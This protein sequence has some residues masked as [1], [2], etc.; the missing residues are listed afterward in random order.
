M[1]SFAGKP[2]VALA[3][4]TAIQVLPPQAAP[5]NPIHQAMLQSSDATW[6]GQKGI[7][8]AGIEMRTDTEGV[9]FNSYLREL[10]LSVKKTWFANM[11]PSLERGE[12]GV[13]A[14][15]FRVLQDGNVPKDSLKMIF[16]SAKSDLDA[17]SFQAIREAAPF[18]HLPEPFAKPYIV[19]RFTFYYNAPIPRN[20]SMSATLESQTV[21]PL[22]SPLIEKFDVWGTLTPDS[23]L[24]FYSG[25]ANGLFT[26]TK[27]P[28]SLALGRCLE[29][30]S[31]QQI[32]A[33]VDKR[34][35]DHREGFKNPISSEMIEAVTVT[36]NP[37]QGI[38][39]GR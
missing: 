38:R 17:A 23:K 20:P 14:V 11:P 4:L 37:C 35:A 28:G 25:W 12:Q 10:Y 16:G 2:L 6:N 33:M 39:V 32:L 31:F 9:D 34:Y 5:A 22:P 29:K 24:A 26:T 36:G 3:L 21:V 19:L 8:G 30:L 13:N 7:A 27:D 15:E 18:K 1:S